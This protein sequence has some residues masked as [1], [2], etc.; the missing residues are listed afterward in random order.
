MTQYFWISS[1]GTTLGGP[2][3][4]QEALQIK[5]DYPERRICFW[6]DDYEEW[7]DVTVLD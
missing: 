2:Y 7:V 1:T 5:K 6:D 3:T 4:Q